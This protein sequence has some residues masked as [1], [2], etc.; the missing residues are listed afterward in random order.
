MKDRSIGQMET[1]HWRCILPGIRSRRITNAGSGCQSAADEHGDEHG[2]GMNTGTVLLFRNKHRDEINMG[3]D[4][5]GPSLLV[6]S[7]LVQG[8]TVVMS[9]ALV[10]IDIQN[11]ITKHYRDIIDNI[12][13]AIDWLWSWK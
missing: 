12:N 13:A 5:K 1:Q 7:L 6:Q 8:G 9:K 10:V 11:D 3:T 4:T 2:D